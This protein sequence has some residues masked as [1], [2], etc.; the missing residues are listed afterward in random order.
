M[1]LSGRD[2]KAFFHKPEAG[3]AGV[4]IFGA[5]ASRVAVHG[6]EV[7][8]KL[9]GPNGAEEMRLERLSAGDIRR[10]PASLQDALKSQGFFP[11]QRVVLV[12][13]GGDGIAKPVG[14]ALEDWRQGDG[15]LIVL[16]GALAARSALRKLFEGAPNAKAAPVYDDPPGRADIEAALEAAGITQ[17][18]PAALDDL[19][20]LG[21]V[22]DMGSFRKALE[23]L[24]LYKLG[25]DTPV[26][27][28]DILAVFPLLAEAGVDEVVGLAADGAVEP[29]SAAL[30]RLAA[31][32]VGPGTISLALAR[33]FRLLLA[34]ATHP[35]G[36]DQALARARPPVFGPRRDRIARQAQRWGARELEKILPALTELEM[37]L[38]S[39]KPIPDRAA[40]ERM[41][42]RIAFTRSRN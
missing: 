16:A 30:S 13:D 40:V 15:F 31:Q 26:T 4:L 1:K 24:A 7:A 14:S 33:H 39:S 8:E 11:G 2:A 22:S 34:A 10:D 27:S 6:M 17:A 20:A 5:D 42:M 18:D 37:Q 32:G 41:L 25:D 23:S 9:I 29:L 3:G 28:E 12:E 19:V 21:R 36:P 38:R 35:Q